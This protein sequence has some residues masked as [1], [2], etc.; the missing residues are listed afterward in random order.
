MAQARREGYGVVLTENV[1]DKVRSIDMALVE[2]EDQLGGGEVIEETAVEEGVKELLLIV[3]WT[4]PLHVVVV[5]D[6]IRHEERIVT[7][8]EPDKDRWSA[9]FR[10]RKP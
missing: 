5:V 4:R 8:Y 7:V 3:E 6:D 9:D 2:F 1:F 10:V